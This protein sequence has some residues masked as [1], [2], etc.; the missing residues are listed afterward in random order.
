MFH[1][2]LT[3]DIVDGGD[4]MRSD[5]FASLTRLLLLEIVAALTKARAL[6]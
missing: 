3:N 5:A 4:S 2:S 1:V 6:D